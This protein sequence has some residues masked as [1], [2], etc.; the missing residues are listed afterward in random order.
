[1]EDTPDI[2]SLLIRLIE[3]IDNLEKLVGAESALTRKTVLA[4]AGLHGKQY[5]GL[6]R[7]I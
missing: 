6:T 7:P 4:V 3:S 5:E 2:V 1:M